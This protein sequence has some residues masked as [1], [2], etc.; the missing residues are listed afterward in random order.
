MLKAQ[1]TQNPFFKK[2]WKL[3]IDNQKTKKKKLDCVVEHPRK[4]KIFLRIK[5]TKYQY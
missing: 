4:L 5:D 1:E 3:K 2:N